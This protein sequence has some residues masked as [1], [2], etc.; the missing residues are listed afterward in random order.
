MLLIAGGAVMGN[1]EEDADRW[2]AS[3]APDS[4]EVWVVP[5]AGHIGA[6]QADAAQWEATVVMF[7]EMAL[8]PCV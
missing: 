8:V 2:I 3:A 7:L 1:A 4:V 5:G 6:I